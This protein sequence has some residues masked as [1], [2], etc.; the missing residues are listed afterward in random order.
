MNDIVNH[1]KLT[2]DAVDKILD[3]MI[4]ESEYCSKVVET[5]FDKPLVTTKKYKN[6]KNYTKS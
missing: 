5:E 3:D 1:T 2:L 6:S 4:K